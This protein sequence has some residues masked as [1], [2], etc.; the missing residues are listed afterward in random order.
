[1]RPPR[2]GRYRTAL[3]VVGFILLAAVSGFAGAAIENH[4]SSTIID[5][6]LSNQ[7]KVVTSQS[8]LI[9]Q[10]AKTVG[11]SVVSVN[12]SI[13][14]GGSSS[15]DGFGLFGF[16][17]PENEQ[18]AGTGIIISSDGLIVTNR[19]V[20]PDGTTSVSVT[21]SDGTELKNVSVV[22]RDEPQ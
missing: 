14:S 4:N 12:V 6:S 13:T 19:H 17:Q 10:I 1:M 7:K 21:L 8:E 9:S 2:D 3:L 15:S 20:V 22:G 5:G 16:S 18:A 11:P